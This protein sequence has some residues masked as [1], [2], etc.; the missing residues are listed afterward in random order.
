MSKSLSQFFPPS[1]MEAEMAEVSS[2]SS[3]AHL[4]AGAVERI[5]DGILD[6]ELFRRPPALQLAGN[7]SEA[8]PIS[9]TA[10][11]DWSQ[12]HQDLL[13]GIFSRLELPDLVYSGVVCMPWH[14][15]YL[16]VRQYGLCSPNQSPYLIYSS[17]DR[18]SN[19]ATLHN[20]S[21]NK[22][23]HFPLPNPPFR[24]RFVIGSSQG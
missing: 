20:L 15:S 9:G 13:V 17:R 11:H 22:Q 23:Y 3:G 8:L 24:S 18:G 1:S 2:N 19:T 14:L 6:L 10:V 16:A 7:G 12:L 4:P 5:V 21:T